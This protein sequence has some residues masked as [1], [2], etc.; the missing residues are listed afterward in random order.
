MT[1]EQMSRV[2]KLE[3]RI[4]LRKNLNFFVL[5]AYSEKKKSFVLFYI[6]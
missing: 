1:I 5:R 4:Y 3:K 2:E 6:L